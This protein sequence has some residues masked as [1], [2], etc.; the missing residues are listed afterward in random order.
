MSE[1]FEERVTMLE[2]GG[3]SGETPRVRAVKSCEFGEEKL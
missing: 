2:R 1:E 3:G